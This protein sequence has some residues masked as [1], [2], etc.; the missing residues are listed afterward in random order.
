VASGAPG[1]TTAAAATDAAGRIA[2]SVRVTDKVDAL[3]IAVVSADGR[4]QTVLPLAPGH[5]FHPAWSPDRTKIAFV[6]A[7]FDGT[8]PEVWMMNADGG[9]RHRLT[10]AGDQPAWSPDGRAIV[11]SRDD[12]LWAMSPDGSGKRMLARNATAPAWS[13]DSKRLAFVRAVAGV[14]ADRRRYRQRCADSYEIYV[15]RAD[16]SEQTRLT[17]DRYYEYNPDWSPTG[18]MI[19]YNGSSSI[20]VM[21]ADGS[22]RRRLPGTVEA[23]DPSWSPDGTRMVYIGQGSYL[24]TIDADGSDKRR[25]YPPDGGAC[26][27]G[28]PAWS[29]G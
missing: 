10:R 16:G 9:W 17:R 11:F 3:R 26:Q 28:E 24:V 5:S 1:S 15:M 21:S 12:D 27:C 18:T 25:L 2:F 20:F 4:Q 22:R 29:R 7:R 6:S 14:C 19:A 8:H 23:D 13:P